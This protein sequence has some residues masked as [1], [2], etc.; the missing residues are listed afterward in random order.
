MPDNCT[1]ATIMKHVNIYTY[2]TARSP[3]AAQSQCEAVGFI[4][5]YPTKTDP[6]TLEKTEV[7][8]G[9]SRYQSELYVLKSA[10]SRINTMC[11]LDIYTESEYVA[12]GFEKWL[13]MWKESSWQTKAGKEVSNRKEWEELEAMV[14]QYG[15]NLTFHTKEHHSYREWLKNNVEK[16]K[17]ICLRNLENSTVRKK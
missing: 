15:H 9:M 12:A 17:A 3:K 16:E 14:Q 8:H 1:G 13:A 4:L 11:E 7:I 10:L 5:E 6:V 2:S